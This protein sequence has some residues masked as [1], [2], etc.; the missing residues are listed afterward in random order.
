MHCMDV[1][2]ITTF[3]VTSR[4]TY[5]ANSDHLDISFRVRTSAPIEFAK[6]APGPRTW[7]GR[8]DYEQ[9]KSGWKWSALPLN[10]AREAHEGDAPME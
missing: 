2:A 6:C 9:G 3:E 4:R 1:D 10:L 5:G 8:I 7:T